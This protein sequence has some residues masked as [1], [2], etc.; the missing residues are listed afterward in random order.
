MGDSGLVIALEP[1]PT[2]QR[3]LRYAVRCSA[4]VVLPYAVGSHSSACQLVVPVAADGTVREQLGS[5]VAPNEMPGALTYEVPCITL[6][7]LWPLLWTRVSLIKIDVEGAEFEVLAGAKRLLSVHRPHLV[8]EIEDRHQPAGRTV[9][10][11][12]DQIKCLGYTLKAITDTGLVEIDSK[13]CRGDQDLRHSW[14]AATNFVA[15]PDLKGADA[16]S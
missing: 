1:N 3:E 13:E 6:D 5:L 8:I 4:C 11:V 12:F 9:Q 10:D 2:L 16:R 14:A 15:E 7:S